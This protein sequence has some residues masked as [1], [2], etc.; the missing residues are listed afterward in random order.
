MSPADWSRGPGISPGFDHSTPESL[1][2]TT[3]ALSIV[4][5]AP[6]TPAADGPTAE[7][8]DLL[9][10]DLPPAPPS[11]VVAVVMAIQA[12]TVGTTLP[13]LEAA[14]DRLAAAIA[15]AKAWPE[16]ADKAAVRAYMEEKR[17][18]IK[19][20]RA[21][22]QAPRVI[23]TPAARPLVGTW[24]RVKTGPH[25]DSWAARIAAELAPTVGE[26][27][28]VSRRDGSRRDHY[29]AELLHTVDNGAAILCLATR[30]PAVAAAATPPMHAEQSIPV[31]TDAPEAPVATIESALGAI[32]TEGASNAATATAGSLASGARRIV[33]FSDPA[34]YL[35]ALRVGVPTSATRTEYIRLARQAGLAFDESTLP[36]AGDTLAANN[37]PVGVGTTYTPVGRRYE[38]MTRA[39][40][41]ALRKVGNETRAKVAAAIS[42]STIIAGAIAAGGMLQV[43]WVGGGTTTLGALRT[44]LATIGREHDAPKAPSQ[45]RHAGRA[46]D[47][48]KSMS[49]DTARLPAADLPDGISAR[50]LVGRK[51][52]GAA[53]KAGGAYGH[54]LLT[55]NLSD[56]GVLTFDG[57]QAIAESIKAHYATAT[58]GEI[59]RSEDLTTW[60]GTTLRDT[61]Y[62]VKSGTHW[63]VPAGEADAARALSECL[64]KLWGDHDR[65]AVTTGKDLM[66]SLTKGLD[67]ELADLAK[68][69]AR[70]TAT[71]TARAADKARKEAIEAGREESRRN[72]RRGAAPF[73]DAQIELLG[74]RAHAAA[75]AKGAMVTPHVGARMLVDLAKIGAKVTGYQTVLGEES[76]ATLEA[77]IAAFAKLLT[78]TCTEHDQ[79]VSMLEPYAKDGE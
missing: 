40:R 74:E 79:V 12:I 78:A 63:Y 57:D 11:P 43:S 8:I 53:V 9:E 24:E 13:E 27:V 6:A 25:A 39:Q 54:A 51:L 47:A 52:T 20:A 10:L 66:R 14:W 71:A 68:E 4:S 30:E 56:G 28:V 21:A 29:I 38:D 23:A 50:W 45:E 7:R 36:P 42:E 60:F 16:G 33:G 76:T 44:A 18:A 49:L 35:A 61:H 19:A 17:D 41:A 31:V 77:Q 34:Q 3:P 64:E 73:T 26:V 32:A 48:Q 15:P 22:V 67:N 59:L 37:L 1:F 72:T 2:M 5:D 70:E 62:S 55:V 69:Y 65:I 46:V 75:T 58:A